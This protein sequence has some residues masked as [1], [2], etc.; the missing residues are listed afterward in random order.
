MASISS[1]SHA[2]SHATAS[3]AC[4]ASP[5]LLRPHRRPRSKQSRH[6]QNSFSLQAAL[7]TPPE[8]VEVRNRLLS[9]IGPDHVSVPSCDYPHMTMAEKVREASCAQV[10]RW[11]RHLVGSVIRELCDNKIPMHSIRMVSIA[12]LPVDFCYAPADEP[13]GPSDDPTRVI[14]IVSATGFV[15]D[16]GIYD[17]NGAFFFKGSVVR[18][19][20]MSAPPL[21]NM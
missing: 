19:H 11:G 12:D 15:V 1:N 21:P 17:F 8:D 20:Y 18:N 3:V 16:T 14:V 13:L 6:C 4:P 2:A 5:A 10:D 9:Y 7:P